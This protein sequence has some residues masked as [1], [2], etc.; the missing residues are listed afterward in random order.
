MK[1]SFYELSAYLGT[2]AG[3]ADVR[4]LETGEPSKTDV[5]IT[6]DASGIRVK[7]E[8]SDN[9]AIANGQYGAS[10]A[11]SG[12]ISLTIDSGS[13]TP[14]A[15]NGENMASKQS[16]MKDAVSTGLGALVGAI[17]GPAVA[18]ITAG[19]GSMRAVSGQVTTKLANGAISTISK[20]TAAKM[21]T[22]EVVQ[23]TTGTIAGGIVDGSSNNQVH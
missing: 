12:A 15:F 18:G 23:G 19:K 4:T 13:S 16:L 22:A 6:Y 2:I 14:V 1:F 20:T 10:S 11:Q 8:I 3:V 5:N 21:A 9:T 17:P 7:K